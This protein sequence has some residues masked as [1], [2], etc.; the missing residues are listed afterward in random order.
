MKEKYDQVVEAELPMKQSQIAKRSGRR[1]QV[2]GLIHCE[3]Y[4]R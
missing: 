3:T 4:Q 1:S 2:V